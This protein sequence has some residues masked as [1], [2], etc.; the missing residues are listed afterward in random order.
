MA[1]PRGF[2]KH[3][4]DATKYRPV[5]E[6]VGDYRCVQQDFPREKSLEQ[7]SRCMDC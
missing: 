2:L 6:R 5:D 1:D 4:R 3:D 7:A